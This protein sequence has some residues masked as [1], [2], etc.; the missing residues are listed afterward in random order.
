MDRPAEIGTTIVIK[1]EITAQED[2][3][4]SGRVE[5][6]ISVD[7]HA[8]TVNDG[9]QVAAQVQARAIVVSGQVMGHLNAAERLELRATADVEGEMSA[10]VLKV[11]EGALFQGKAKTTGDAKAKLQLAS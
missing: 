8:V 7:G 9:A 10:P 11:A 2:L 4:I 1:G 3:V 6:S 5:G